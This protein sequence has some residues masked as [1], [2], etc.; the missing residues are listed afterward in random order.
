MNGEG[1]TRESTSL[2][3][4]LLTSNNREIIGVV[5]INV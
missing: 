1:G 5:N 3:F 2:F 4:V